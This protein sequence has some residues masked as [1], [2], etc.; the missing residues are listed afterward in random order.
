MKKELKESENTETKLDEEIERL[1]FE[2]LKI[3]NNNNKKLLEEKNKFKEL[4][5][6]L[7]AE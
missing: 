5:S 2:K 6:K 7:I 4:E 1:S 3:E